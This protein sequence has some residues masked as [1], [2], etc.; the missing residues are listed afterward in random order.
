M[1]RAEG[2]GGKG[3]NGRCR[4]DV[5]GPEGHRWERKGGN[6]AGFCQVPFPA[7]V[8]GAAFRGSYPHGGATFLSVLRVR[9]VGFPDLRWA[10]RVGGFGGSLLNPSPTV[11]GGLGESEFFCQGGSRPQE[12]NRVR[13]YLTE[14]CSVKYRFQLPCGVPPPAGPIPMAGPFFIGGER[15]V[16]LKGN[17]Q[18][19]F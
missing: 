1:E 19:R 15:G 8:R 13:D 16:A 18:R 4:C 3:E 9:G 17:L 10:V 2:R 6:G 14:C 7:T 12:R 11:G 5:D